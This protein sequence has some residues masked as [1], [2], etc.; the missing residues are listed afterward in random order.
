MVFTQRSI[1]NRESP[2]LEENR[3][4]RIELHLAREHPFWGLT[5][6]LN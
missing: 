5:T 4:E 2:D 3:S 6:D 1:L